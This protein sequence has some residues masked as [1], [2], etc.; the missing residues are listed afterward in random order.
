MNNCILIVEDDPI[1]A[2]SLAELLT[3]EGYTI[4]G[5]AKA[6]ADAI[7]ACE[8]NSH[9]PDIALCDIRLWNNEKGTELA[10]LLV[11]RYACEIIFLTAYG[12]P[13]TLQEA[14]KASPVMYVVK[15]YNNLQL[16]VAVQMAFYKIFEQKNDPP[17][18]A[19]QLTA[20][21]REIML[22]IAKGLT[23]RQIAQ[24]TGLS[25]ETIKT[26]RKNALRRNAISSIPQLIFLMQK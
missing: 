14:F 10:L 7:A 4:I 11:Q 17:D 13:S 22:L 12:D 24:K 15:P 18:T 9:W 19:I 21:E 20:R 5:P 1:A 6:A 8:K 2:S 3:E 25:A 16:L 23:T 26:H